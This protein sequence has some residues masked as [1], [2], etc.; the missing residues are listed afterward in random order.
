[1]QNIGDIVFRL[2]MQNIGRNCDVAWYCFPHNGMACILYKGGMVPWENSSNYGAPW[3]LGPRSYFRPF[4]MRQ[5]PLYSLLPKHLP[6]APFSCSQRTA[7]FS[8]PYT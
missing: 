1:M 2:D 7:A 6:S 5:V 3:S 8:T 4:K